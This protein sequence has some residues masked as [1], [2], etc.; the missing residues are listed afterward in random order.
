[1]WKLCSKALLCCVPFT[2]HSILLYSP[3]V[4][5]G[6]SSVKSVSEGDN[7]TVHVACEY[8]GLWDRLGKASP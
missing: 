2:F 5:E 8:P 7:K 1:M 3:L 4:I 6:L